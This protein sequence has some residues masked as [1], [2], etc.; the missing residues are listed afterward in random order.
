MSERH[1]SFARLHRPGQPLFLPNAWDYA[2]ADALARRLATIPVLLTVVEVACRRATAY[3]AAGADGVF[4]PAV[5]D[6]G[7]IMMLASS[8]DAP[9]NVLYLPGQHPL[10]QLAAAGPV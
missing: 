8:V 6:P 2:T 1:E 9:L 7:L 4:V 10:E 3:A 5:A